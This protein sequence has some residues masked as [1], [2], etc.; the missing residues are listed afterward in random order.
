[1]QLIVQEGRAIVSLMA[2]IRAHDEVLRT[3]T[4]SEMTE[5]VKVFY[6][7]YEI[8]RVEM[9]DGTIEVLPQ[10]IAGVFWI[11]KGRRYQLKLSN[12]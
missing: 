8:V 11:E 5:N 6:R 1:M 10:A 3:N 2:P 7:D 12:E 9:R 4:F